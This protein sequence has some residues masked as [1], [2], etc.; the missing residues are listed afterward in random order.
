LADP[1]ADGLLIYLML[2]DHHV[3]RGFLRLG[4]PEDQIE[5]NLNQLVKTI[6]QTIM[7]LPKLHRKPVIGFS[8]RSQIDRLIQRLQQKGFP[9]LPSP[10]RAARAMAALV[11][12][13]K[14]LK[15]QDSMK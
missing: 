14:I 10:E 6:S 1:E 5:D 2:P 11:Q 12:Y 9:V 13:Q 7:G 8:Y 4:I 15:V 3:R